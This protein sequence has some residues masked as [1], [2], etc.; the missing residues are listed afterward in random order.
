[1]IGPFPPEQPLLQEGGEEGVLVA[2]VHEQAVVVAARRSALD[3]QRGVVSE[4]Q[5][6]RDR[7]A[8]SEMAFA[9]VAA[10][11]DSVGNPCRRVDLAIRPAPRLSRN[12]DPDLEHRRRYLLL[13][14]LLRLLLPSPR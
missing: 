6:R 10:N 12:S 14:I 3:Q 8:T 13:K 7:L 5:R 2:L 11:I 4:S 9:A 1:M